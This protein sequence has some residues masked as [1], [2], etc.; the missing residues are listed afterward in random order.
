MVS[1]TKRRVGQSVIIDTEN[2][3]LGSN[4]ITIEVAGV[5]GYQVRLGIDVPNGF[6]IY[7]K[8]VYEARK[9]KKQLNKQGE[10]C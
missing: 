4:P 10:I 6:K 5:Q 8:E 7:R 2:D 1:M 9:A 3:S